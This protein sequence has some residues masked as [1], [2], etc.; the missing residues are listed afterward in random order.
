MGI[1]GIGIDIVEVARIE[2]QKPAFFERIFTPA[3]TA[4]CRS[5]AQPALHFAVRFA[6]KEATVKALSWLPGTLTVTQVEVI[7]NDETGAPELKIVP[8]HYKEDPPA[9]PT[10]LRLHVSLSHE[11]SHAIATVIA[12]VL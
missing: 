8:G 2:K 9:L 6:A 4:Y 10:G 11:K 3:E 1:R 12:E 5:Q 7:R